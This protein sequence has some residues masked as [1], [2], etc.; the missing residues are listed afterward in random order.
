[1]ANSYIYHMRWGFPLIL[2]GICG[3]RSE[4]CAL[5]S[6]EMEIATVPCN[7]PLHSGAS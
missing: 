1:M 4:E 3:E 2:V 7:S 5:V 6:N